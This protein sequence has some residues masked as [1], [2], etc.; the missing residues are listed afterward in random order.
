MW[1]HIILV[2]IIGRAPLISVCVNVNYGDRMSV[3]LFRLFVHVSWKILLIYIYLWSG[4]WTCRLVNIIECTSLPP[5]TPSAWLERVLAG[6]S[7]PLYFGPCERINILGF[8]SPTISLT[9]LLQKVRLRKLYKKIRRN[10]YTKG[11]RIWYPA[12]TC[13]SDFYPI[14]LVFRPTAWTFFQFCRKRGNFLYV[15][16]FDWC[17]LGYNGPRREDVKLKEYTPSI[18]YLLSLAGLSNSPG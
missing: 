12:Y 2:N 10:E 17:W 5:S 7:G 1:L 14:C 3:S 13:W 9:T 16:L 18:L 11:P 6:R 15:T 4:F 8:S